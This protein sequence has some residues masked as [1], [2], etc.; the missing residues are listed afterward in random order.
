MMQCYKVIRKLIQL[1]IVC[2]TAH[3]SIYEN[4]RVLLHASTHFKHM[5]QLNSNLTLIF[6]YSQVFTDFIRVPDQ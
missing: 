5:V 3:S 2:D 1:Y 4:T 6:D